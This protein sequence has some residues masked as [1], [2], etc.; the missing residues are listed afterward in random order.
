MLA[1]TRIA[2]KIKSA[3]TC[4]VAASVCTQVDSVVLREKLYA[5]GILIFP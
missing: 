2:C 1:P 4:I 5:R 3:V